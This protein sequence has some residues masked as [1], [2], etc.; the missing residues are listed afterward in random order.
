MLSDALEICGLIG[1]LRDIR[2]EEA[3]EIAAVLY[4]AGF[5]VLEVPLNSPDPLVSLERMKSFLPRDCVV[6]AGTVFR[7]S[8]VE[9]V[10]RAGGEL[11][12]MPH[13]DRAVIEA[14]HA[15]HLE[16]IPGVATPTEAFAAYGAGATTLK[17]FPAIEI[18]QAALNAWLS[19]LPSNVSLIPV[20]GITPKNLGSFSN[21][22]FVGFG[23][24]SALY[25]PH[26][27]SNEVKQRGRDFISAWST[28]TRPFK[29]PR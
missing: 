4:E 15:A 28:A 22:R 7:S 21:K 11:I 17:V 12:V 26:L 24:G 16:V 13:C 5:R 10:R 6:G 18:G 29:G 25:T 14:A 3:L 9:E 23:L 20:G 8:Q 27:T 2:P 19:V 1:I